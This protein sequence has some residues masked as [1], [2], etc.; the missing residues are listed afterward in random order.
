MNPGAGMIV[1]IAEVTPKGVARG[2]VLSAQL[3]SKAV[4]QG[5]GILLQLSLRNDTEEAITIWPGTLAIVLVTDSPFASKDIGY[6]D[7]E[8]DAYWYHDEQY[9]V[10]EEGKVRLRKRI[11]C[12][13]IMLP[14]TGKDL[15]SRGHKIHVADEQQ[16]FGGPVVIE[17]KGKFEADYVAGKELLPDD[18]E[19]FFCLTTS[20]G[21]SEVPG[22]MSDRLPFD[23]VEPAAPANGASLRR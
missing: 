9:Y 19:V 21:F 23:V 4:V 11:A 8:D 16:G 10:F 22:P 18:Y 12:R 2:L 13:Q 7:P 14:W 15:V 6:K 20:C 17:P 3:K 1:E 5:Q